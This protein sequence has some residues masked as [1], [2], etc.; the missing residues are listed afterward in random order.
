[1]AISSI[2]L[3]WL[4]ECVT[5]LWTIDWAVISRPFPPLHF[6][7]LSSTLLVMDTHIQFYGD[8]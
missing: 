3:Y 6:P 1:M 5:G 4:H 7:R 8:T 2:C